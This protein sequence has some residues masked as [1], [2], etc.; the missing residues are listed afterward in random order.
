MN[1]QKFNKQFDVH[2]Y[3]INKDAK[4]TPIAMLNYLE[5]CAVAHSESIGYGIDK[6]K[7]QGIGWILKRWSVHIIKYPARNEKVI[8]ETWPSKFERFYA[9]REY[10]IKDQSGEIIGRV[11]S[12]WILVSIEKKRPQRIPKQLGEAYG[13]DPIKAV[14][15]SFSELFWVGEPELVKEFQVRRSDIDTNNHVNNTKYVEWILECVPPEI[16]EDYNL[17]DL[18]VEYK[19][20]IDYGFS[21]TS[22]C[23]RL[24]EDGGNCQCIHS[25]VNRDTGTELAAAKT[26]WNK[27]DKVKEEE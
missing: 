16:Y 3:E 2:Y 1:K 6:L 23:R 26:M 4:A 20:E 15:E 5:E 14:E 7:E 12:L 22:N 24:V 18:E 9:H 11:S 8:V 27:K 17:S 25:I 21:I 10:M 19:K 13:L